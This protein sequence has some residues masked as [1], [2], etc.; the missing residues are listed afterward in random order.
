MGGFSHFPAIA[1]DVEK[2][3]L[4]WIVLYFLSPFNYA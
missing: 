3:A 1:M 2:K 4:F